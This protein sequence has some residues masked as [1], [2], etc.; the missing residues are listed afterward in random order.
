MKPFSRTLPPFLALLVLCGGGPTGAFADPVPETVFFDLP[1]SLEPNPIPAASAQLLAVPGY[2][3]DPNQLTLIG[4]FYTP[5]AGVHGQGPYPTVLVLHG[6][7]GMWSSDVIAN[8]P[9][10]EFE[11]WAEVLT[12]LGYAM[13]LVD[14]FNPRGI[15]G[16]YANRRPHHDPGIDDALCSPNYERPKDVVAALAFLANRPEVDRECIGLLGFSHGSQAGLNSILDASVDLGVYTVDYVNAN[17]EVEP[18]VV[19]PPVRIPG[20][21]PF[22]RV[23]AFYY[24][25]C[26]HFGYHGQ[27]SSVAAGRYMP[28]RRTHVLMFH[29]TE[30]SLL[31]VSD[32]DAAPLTGSLFPIK[33]VASSALQAAAEG[34]SN[35]FVQHTIFDHA[36]HSFDLTNI[37]PP[38]NWNTVSESADEKAKRLARD[39]VLK[40]FECFLKRPDLHPKADPL[41]P[42]SHFV[43][44]TGRNQ[45]DYQLVSNEDLGPVWSPAGGNTVGNGGELE[46]AVMVPP[47]KRVFFRLEYQPT[48]VPASDPEN[49]GFILDYGDFSY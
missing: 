17:D 12:D 5:D 47:S 49:L 30:D 39:E 48:P 16:N 3:N 36:A 46:R 44:W 42:G 25:G 43:A 14:S 34:I 22:P 38:Q 41:D 11:D 40:W 33:F 19:A 37:E 20:H 1:E 45:V 21:L 8:G 9:G 6:S 26:G 29:G 13:L 27:S 23:A 7:G 32:P 35:P 24:P 15:Q 10:S 31:G 28:D 2:P 18:L 4:Q